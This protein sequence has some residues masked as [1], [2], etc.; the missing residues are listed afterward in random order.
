MIV[1]GILTDKLVK[2]LK[3]LTKVYEIITRHGD[4]DDDFRMSEG[5]VMEV[6]RLFDIII[7]FTENH[8]CFKKNK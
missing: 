4:Q 6:D 7:D 8:R 5:D 2:A 1:S 3:E